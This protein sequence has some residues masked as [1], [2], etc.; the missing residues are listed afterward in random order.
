MLSLKV[1]VPIACFRPGT[2]REFW[3]TLPL[4]PPSTVYGFLLSLVGERD[5]DQHL[6]VR[7]TSGV[8]GKLE[9][10]MVL[11]R[12]WRI[13]ELGGKNQASQGNGANVRPDYQQLLTNVELLVFLD[14]SDEPQDRKNLETR[15]S[16][17]LDREKRNQIDRF[18]GLSLGESTHM[19]D[20]V[21]LLQE[22][23]EPTMNQARV[24]L[25]DAVGGMTLPVWVDHVGSAGTR[26]ATGSLVKLNGMPTPN[27]IPQISDGNI[28]L[29]ASA[30][31]R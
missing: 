26:Y 30:S 28:S 18:G 15:V 4:P 1:T 22:I 12:M 27:Q 14:S 11:R 10:S 21:K 6:G 20:E 23:D 31:T 17:A 24:F 19:V 9:I 2:A 29:P 5:R 16:V 8:I 25:L 3:E 7:C 13:K